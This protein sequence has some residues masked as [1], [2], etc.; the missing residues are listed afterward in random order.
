MERQLELFSD[1]DLPKLNDTEEALL[2]FMQRCL[3]LEEQVKE[4]NQELA[5]MRGDW[6]PLIIEEPEWIASVFD[7][8]ESQTMTLNGDKE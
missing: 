3:T 5:S 1:D 7:E 4:L 6:R 8:K 2:H